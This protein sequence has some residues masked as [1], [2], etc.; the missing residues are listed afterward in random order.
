[1]K[2]PDLAVKPT[3]GKQLF[4][5]VDSQN[6]VDLPTDAYLPSGKAPA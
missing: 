5:D 3:L 2:Y 6:D 1:V 4:F